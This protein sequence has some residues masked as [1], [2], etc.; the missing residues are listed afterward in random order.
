MRHLLV[1]PFILGPALPVLA[2]ETEPQNPAE[3]SD[4]ENLATEDLVDALLMGASGDRIGTIDNVLVLEDDTD[5]VVVGTGGYGDL[6]T[7][8]VLLELSDIRIERSEDGTVAATTS[9]TQAE[10]D[11][12]AAYESA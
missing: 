1:L 4:L 7:R 2:Q 6:S 10:I 3:V 9:L 11:A 5:K 8:K 12:L